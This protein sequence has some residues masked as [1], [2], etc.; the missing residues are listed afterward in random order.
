MVLGGIQNQED[1]HPHLNL[2]LKLL[3]VE[4]KQ[5]YFKL[6]PLPS[7]EFNSASAGTGN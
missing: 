6:K 1:V 2:K 7:F 3:N 4:R 5:N